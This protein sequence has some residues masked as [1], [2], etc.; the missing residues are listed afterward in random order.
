MLAS[1]LSLIS[2]GGDNGQ[3]DNPIVIDKEI[4]QEYQ[5]EFYDR[6]EEL[7]RISTSAVQEAQPSEEKK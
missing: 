2:I 5:K 1:Q 6:K 7:Q 3:K 4:A